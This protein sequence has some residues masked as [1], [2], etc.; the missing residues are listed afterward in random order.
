MGRSLAETVLALVVL[1]AAGLFGATLLSVESDEGPRG[2]LLSAEFDDVGGLQPGAPVR[3]GGMTV[4]EVVDVRLDPITYF[5]IVEMALDDRV[6]TPADSR[7]AIAAGGLGGVASIAI[8]P[9]ASPSILPNGGE[10]RNTSSPVNVVDQLGRRVF[11][12]LSSDGS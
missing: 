4:G 8:I 6:R 12:G 10:I 11:G 9:G 3:L 7:A 5:A 2:Y 1:I